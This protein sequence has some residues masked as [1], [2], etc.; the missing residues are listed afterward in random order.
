MR[1]LCGDTDM[2]GIVYYGTY[3]RYFEA[4][5]NELLRAFDLPY[6]EIEAMGFAMPVT[7]VSVKYRSPARYDDDLTLETAVAEMGN[8]SFRMTYR[9]SRARD[10]QLVCAGETVHACVS[11]KDGRVARLPDRIRNRFSAAG[12]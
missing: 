6:P 3:L 7:E 9:L 11:R 5:R 10:E 2:M 1:V 12:A 8:A 4:G